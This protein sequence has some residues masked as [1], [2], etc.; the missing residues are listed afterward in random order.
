MERENRRVS[1]TKRLLKEGLLQLL[2]TR[3]LENIRV[4]ELCEVSGVNRATF[5]R[6][7]TLPKDL[8]AEIEG[9]LIAELHRISPLPESIK[10]LESYLEEFCIC[11]QNHSAC[12]Q[13]LLRCGCVLKLQDSIN[14]FCQSLMH[15]QEAAQE[16][17]DPLHLQMRAAFLTGGI[18]L[19]LRRWILE[20][21]RQS[22]AEIAKFVAELLWRE[23]DFCSS[24]AG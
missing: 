11:L 9:D 18:G 17:E 13:M 20:S 22:P 7:Y 16:R 3:K 5:Y 6:H 21:E 8:L 24:T 15:G 2:E 10:E 14:S 12:V 23:E 19:M 1:M 4:T